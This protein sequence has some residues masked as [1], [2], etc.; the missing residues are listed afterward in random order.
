MVLAHTIEAV[1]N[2]RITR[3][4][5]NTCHGQHV[6]RAKPPGT[7]GKGTRSRSGEAARAA[8]KPVRDYATLLRGRDAAS[9][10]AY[11]TTERFKD[12]D[13]IRHATFGLGLVTEL[14]DGNKIDVLFADGSK[15]L[16]H[17]RG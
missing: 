16:I 6:Y 11:G 4:H 3:V 7:S 1:V 12:G 9:A 15:T 5:C 8:A 2:G 14:R 13:L 17:R 10:R